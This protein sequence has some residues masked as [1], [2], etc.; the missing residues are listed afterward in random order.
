MLT[1]EQAHR[2][3]QIHLHNENVACRQKHAAMRTLEEAGCLHR[4]TQSEVRA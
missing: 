2:V 1:P 3:A 4:R